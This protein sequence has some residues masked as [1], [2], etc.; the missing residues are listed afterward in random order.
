MISR[1]ATPDLNGDIDRGHVIAAIVPCYNEEAAVGKVVRDLRQAVPGVQVY[2]YDNCSTD[3]TAAA[4]REVGATVRIEG[5]KGKG[6]VVRRAF[7]DI[8][9]DIYLLIDGDDTYDAAAAPE[10]VETLLAGPYDHVLGVREP[11]EDASQA[12]RP[13]HE[14]GN[15]MLNRVVASLF[16]TNAGDMLSG[17]RAFSRRFV[18]TFPASSHGFEIETELTVHSLSLRIPGAA[19]PVGFRER[20]AGSESK[21]HTVRDGLRILH[22]ILALARHEKPLKFYGILAAMGLL[23]AAGLALGATTAPEL[24]TV[25]GM[26]ALAASFAMVLGFVLDGVKRSR[27]EHARLN[28]LS[29]YSVPGRAIRSHEVEGH[30]IVPQARVS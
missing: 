29:Y 12:Y 5:R 11:D 28:Y 17:Y 18:K 27:H 7:A 6:N 1:V 20:P 26:V 21:L 16:G 9:A 8:E 14:F 10:L 13:A 24:A 4:A 30:V 3:N 15:R 23:A 22:L 19:L 25:A 2:V